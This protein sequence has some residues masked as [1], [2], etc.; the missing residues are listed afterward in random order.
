MK[1]TITI[2]SALLLITRLASADLNL[3][4]PNLN[5][6]SLG[7][8]GSIISSN[9]PE[10][11]HGLSIL[12]KLRSQGRLVEDPEINTWIRSLGNRLTANAPRSITPFYFVV[13]RD[14]SVNAFAT[15]GGVIVINTGL[16]LESE[17]ESE[18][19]AVMA[20]EIAHITQRHIFRMIDNSKNNKLARSATLLAGII[21]SSKNSQA[22][23]AIITATAATM[24]HKQLAFSRSAESEADRVGI[25]I[26]ARSGFNPKAMPSFL[27]KLDKFSNNEDSDIREFLQNHPLTLKRISD[28]QVRARSLGFHKN[29]SNN[30]YLYMKEKARSISN[31]SRQAPSLLP[32]KIKNYSKALRQAKLQK[33]AQALQIIGSGSKQISEALLIATLLNKQHKYKE[34]IALLT[35]LSD[36]YIGNES[37]SIS[38]ANVYLSTG[39]RQLAWQILDNVTESEQTS[40]IYFETKQRTASL[41]GNN[42]E[43][44]RSAAER[45]IRMGNYKSAIAL[46]TRAIKSPHTKASQL[47]QMQARL[48][49]I[50]NK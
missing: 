9:F 19:A 30:S 17:S 27:K 28:T 22:G 18:L 38:L 43:A 23:Q 34:V 1:K 35:P 47:P 44:Y 6:P 3:E 14:L 46:L 39:Q 49:Q 13:S 45:N 32:K 16:I 31:T 33:Y 26:L 40:L 50:K 10:R 5:L 7:D 2:I 42:S 48:T 24:A 37:L 21:A 12:R 25:R 15:I 29:K 8:Q 4:L 36:L 11:E 41:I 20:H